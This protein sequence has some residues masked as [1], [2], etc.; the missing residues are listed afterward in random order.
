MPCVGGRER[1]VPSRAVRTLKIG[2]RTHVSENALTEEGAV[3]ETPEGFLSRGCEA[4]GGMRKAV[5]R[6]EGPQ[7]SEV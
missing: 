5:L 1:S 7:V 4:G 3:R 2:F 6:Q